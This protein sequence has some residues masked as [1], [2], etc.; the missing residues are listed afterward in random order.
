AARL[1]DLLEKHGSKKSL[2]K[3][4]VTG[5][6]RTVTVFTPAG[7]GDAVLKNVLAAIGFKAYEISSYKVLLELA[8]AAGAGDDK[9]I[10]EQSMTETQDIGDWLGSHIPGFVDS[11]LA[12]K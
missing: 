10:L 2:L 4:A 9:P 12:H 8:D 1:D 5:A 11:Y 3:E 7:A 6:V